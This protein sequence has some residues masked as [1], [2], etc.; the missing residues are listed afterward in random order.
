QGWPG[1]KVPP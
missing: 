1:P